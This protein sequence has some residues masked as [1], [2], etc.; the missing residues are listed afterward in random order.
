MPKFIEFYYDSS[1]PGQRI[2]ALKCLPDDNFRAIVQIVHGI[3]EH[4]DRYRPF[5]EFLAEHGILAVGNDHL[6]HGKTPTSEA[7][8]GAFYEE[9]GWNRVVQDV[10]ALHDLVKKDLPVRVPYVMFGHSMG[11]FV[12]RTFMIDHPD[13]FDMAIISGT[14]HQGRALV[15]FGNLVASQVIK[16]KG[17]R[18]DG[19][20]LNKLAMGNYLKRIKEPR[21]DCDWL[22]NDAEQ[23]NKYIQDALCGFTAKAGMYADMLRGV[24]YVTDPANIARMP[25]DKPVF[26][27]SG[28]ED[29]VGDYGLG[30]RKAAIAFHDAGLSDVKVKLYEGGRHE[31]LNELNRKEVYRNILTWLN[32]RID[33][34][35]P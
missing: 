15:R 20:F 28:S 22:S 30:V 6:G 24:S 9:D 4:I 26:F 10:A 23:V 35:Q 29:P 32:R 5:M 33:R 7:D 3:S 27:M 11:S 16:R 12:V 17:Y 19:T 1:V 8:Q 2:R 31:M 21:T 34:W 13:K 18:S 25:K 14:G